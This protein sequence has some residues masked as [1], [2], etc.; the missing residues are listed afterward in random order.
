MTFVRLE[1]FLVLVNSGA[2][3]LLVSGVICQVDSDKRTRL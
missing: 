1:T 3:P 2:W